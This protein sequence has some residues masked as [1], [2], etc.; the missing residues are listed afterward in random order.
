MILSV[1]IHVIFFKVSFQDP[2]VEDNRESNCKSSSKTKSSLKQ[3]KNKTQL[4][5]YT[6]RSRPAKSKC[7]VRNFSVL[8]VRLV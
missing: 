7:Y 2:K 3:K 4:P 5:E 8:R 1:L 6:L